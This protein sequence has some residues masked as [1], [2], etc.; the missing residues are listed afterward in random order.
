MEVAVADDAFQVQ[1]YQNESGQSPFAQWFNRLNPAAAAKITI[2]LYRLRQG[3]F[4][5]VKGVGAGVYQYKID[6]GPGYRSYCGKDGE[7]VIILLGGTDKRN[8]C[9]VSLCR[10]VS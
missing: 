2:A 3:N 5:N 7:R 4:S 9:L 1:E 10:H 6:F 8:A